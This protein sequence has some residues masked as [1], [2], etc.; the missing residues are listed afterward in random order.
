MAAWRWL[1]HPLLFALYFVVTL[2]ASN[3]SD[4]KGWQDLAWPISIS[5][6]VCILCWLAALAWT[7]DRQKAAVLC[8]LWFVAFSVYGYVAETLRLS[9]ALRL[10]GSEAGLGGL[11]V[12]ALFGPSLAINRYPRRLEVVNQY[13]TLV[14]LCLV[15]FTTVQL[16][17]GLAKDRDPAPTLPLPTVVEGQASA[18]DRP[19]IYLII[20]DKYTGGELL[21]DHFGFDNHEFEAYLK[22]RGFVV[23]RSGQANYPQTPL[24]LASMLNLDYL[25]NLP[26]DLPL[27]DL[28][29]N[30]RLAGFLKQQGYRFA[31]FPTGFRVTFQN[32]NADLQLPPP[33]EVRGEFAAVWQNTTILPE[34]LSGACTLLGCEGGR[35]LITAQAAG[36]MDWKFERLKDLSGG[37]TP[38]FVLAH[39]SLPHEPFLYHADC[40]HRD[41]YWPVGAGLPDDDEAN[42]GYLDQIRC[43][44]RKLTTV[45]DSILSRSRRPAVILLQSDHGHGRIGHLPPFEKLNAYQLRERM[46]VFAAYR[47]PGIPP[48]AVRDSVT[49]VN[50]LRL[51]LRHYFGADLPPL[52]DASYWGLEDKPFDLV[53]IKW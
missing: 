39:L 5:V 49:P 18:G 31:F 16:Y 38:T 3:T 25:Q 50:A 35:F 30:N 11:F 27:Y 15:G 32:R 44:N 12:L 52:E 43:A 7:R 33:R 20:L 28:I 24:A 45:V 17:L 41:L 23:P 46:S 19:D 9:G 37:D 51:T 4:L 26:R 2:A 8:L 13:A 1:L 34:L 48:G 36:M 21:Q 53:R 6:L 22:S 10:I 47:L 40:S 42:R 29:E 14:G